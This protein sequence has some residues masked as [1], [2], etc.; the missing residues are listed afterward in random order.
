[1]GL[2]PPTKNRLC[3]FLS[4]SQRP[5]S[6]AGTSHCSG[7]VMCSFPSCQGGKQ[8]ST[9]S[10][11]VGEPW[12]FSPQALCGIEFPW[13]KRGVLLLSTTVPSNC[14]SLS[15]LQT[16]AHTVPFVSSLL[17]RQILLILEISS[18]LD[19]TSPQIRARCHSIVLLLQ[20]VLSPA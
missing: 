19:V 10:V 4:L 3:H 9:L 7:L 17:S 6:W 18:L 1:M 15:C 5:K 14:H 16:F 11:S 2:S 12:L 13:R 8:G 20:P